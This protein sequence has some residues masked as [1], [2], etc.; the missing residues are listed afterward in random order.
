V[1]FADVGLA[2][3]VDDGGLR[4]V[5]DV[6]ATARFARRLRVLGTTAKEYRPC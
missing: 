3:P 6:I 4:H 2:T 1:R 5:R